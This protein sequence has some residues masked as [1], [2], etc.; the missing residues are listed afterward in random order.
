MVL[1]NNLF[2]IVYIHISYSYQDFIKI[3]NKKSVVPSNLNI[4]INLPVENESNLN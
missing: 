3:P 2:R 1:I 4:P